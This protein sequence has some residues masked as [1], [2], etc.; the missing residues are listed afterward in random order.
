M[1]G[2]VDIC[3]LLLKKGAKVNL[4]DKVGCNCSVIFNVV[5]TEKKEISGK[6]MNSVKRAELLVD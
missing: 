1:T 4:K 6:M 5:T 3:K 2:S